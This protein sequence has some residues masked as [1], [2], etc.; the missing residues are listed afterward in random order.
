MVLPAGKCTVP[1]T[2]STCPIKGDGVQVL[3]SHEETSLSFW[4]LNFA[5][6]SW[7][8]QMSCLADSEISEI[9]FSSN[10][11]GSVQG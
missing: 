3:L 5:S 4:S 7:C 8:L 10:V 6:V 11:S 2:S 9:S 1:H